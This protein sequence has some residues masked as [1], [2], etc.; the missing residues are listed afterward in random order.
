MITTNLSSPSCLSTPFPDSTRTIAGRRGTR[1]TGWMDWL[2]TGKGKG[3]E[4]VLYVC[5]K[6]RKNV[7]RPDDSLILVHVLPPSHR[8]RFIGDHRTSC[9]SGPPKQIIRYDCV[10]PGQWVPQR[11]VVIIILMARQYSWARIKEYNCSLNIYTGEV[12]NWRQKV[13]G[14]HSNWGICQVSC[15]NNQVYRK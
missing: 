5:W 4:L 13:S 10:V 15:T 7:A 12:K 14:S 3:N 11:A 8:S 9:L 6:R 2:A 1:I